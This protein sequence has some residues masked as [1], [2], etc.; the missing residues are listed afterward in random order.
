MNHQK[1]PNNLQNVEISPALKKLVF[2]FARGQS[3]RKNEEVGEGRKRENW[4]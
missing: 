3:I 2:N 1:Q 4:G